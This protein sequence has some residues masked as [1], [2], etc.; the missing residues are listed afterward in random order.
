[1]RQ[2]PRSRESDIRTRWISANGTTVN[3]LFGAIF[4]L[5]LFKAQRY[6][7]VTRCFLVLAMAG[8]SLS[9]TFCFP[10]L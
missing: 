4:W 3:L 10:A 5:L 6:K 1:M 9:A 7:P 2:G 8:T